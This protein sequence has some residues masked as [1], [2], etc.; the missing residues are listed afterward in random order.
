MVSG[1]V[2]VFLGFVVVNCDWSC[3]AEFNNYWGG[4]HWGIDKYKA[5]NYLSGFAET[6]SFQVMP[7]IF[8]SMF[9]CVDPI[10]NSR[11]FVVVQLS[12]A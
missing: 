11:F 5:F 9:I 3:A 12:A 2:Y 7:R 10:L 6:W 4:G 8:R 1:I